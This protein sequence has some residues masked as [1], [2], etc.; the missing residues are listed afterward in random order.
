MKTLQD[1]LNTGNYFTDKGNFP[2]SHKYFDGVYL[3]N[4]IDTYESLFSPYK[5]KNINFLEIGIFN[6]GSM[7]LWRD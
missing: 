7:M 3:H 2:K 5:D 4:Y 6:G 1:L